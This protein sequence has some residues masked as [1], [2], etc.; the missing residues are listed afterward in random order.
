MRM[1]KFRILLYRPL[2]G[3]PIEIVMIMTRNARRPC[4]PM[5]LPA[6]LNTRADAAS[7]LFGF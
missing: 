7:S 1:S 3:A 5:R 6:F 2:S 4:S